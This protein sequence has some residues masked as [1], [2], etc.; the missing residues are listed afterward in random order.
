[1][2]AE[3]RDR[4]RSMALIHEK[5]YQSR[6]LSHIDFGEYAGSLTSYLARSYTN[7]SGVNISIDI[8]DISLDI[9]TAIPCGLIINELV[10]NSLK[11]AFKDGRA[12]EINVSLHRSG[13]KYTLTVSDNGAGLPDGFDFRD[14]PSLGLQLVN[15]L[16][17]QIEGT[18]ELDKTAGTIFTIRFEETAGK[19]AKSGAR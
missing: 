17:E 9:D 15:T 6:D 19:E 18:I 10:S 5:L 12:G 14:S 1:M 16:V 2:L 11:Y 13:G 4:V 8:E 7:N 3:S